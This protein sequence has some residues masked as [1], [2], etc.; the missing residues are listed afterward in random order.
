MVGDGPAGVLVAFLLA[1][2]QREGR[3]EVARPLNA[4]PACEIICEGALAQRA[5]AC[6]VEGAIVA[7]TG[8]FRTSQP[9][10]FEGS[11]LCVLRV[12]AESI[13]CV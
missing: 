6:V 5:L 1:D 12:E 3:A 9:P 7:V 4:H 10:G 11:D 8:E 2:D 13:E